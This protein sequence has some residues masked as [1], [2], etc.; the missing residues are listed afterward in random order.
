MKATTTTKRRMMIKSCCWL[1][2]LRPRSSAA[3][4]LA[5]SFYIGTVYSTLSIISETNIPYTAP[6]M[7]Q[8]VYLPG[9]W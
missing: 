2:D 6:L 8:T 4:E 1:I 7:I 3:I 5:M 9:E